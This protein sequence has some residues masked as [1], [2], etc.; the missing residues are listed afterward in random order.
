MNSFGSRRVSK[1]K[2]RVRKVWVP[3]TYLRFIQKTEM[4]EGLT[5]SLH[6]IS[7]S[8]MSRKQRGASGAPHAYSWSH[9][10]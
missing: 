8:Q 10:E 4:W 3:H 7:F 6:S 9:S 5:P 2:C 1:E